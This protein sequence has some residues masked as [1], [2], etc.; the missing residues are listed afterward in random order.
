MPSLTMVTGEWPG[1][2]F[3]ISKDEMVIGQRADCDIFLPD[4]YVSK[5]HALIVR[6]PDGVYVEN[7]KNKNKTRVGGVLLTDPRRLADGDLIE[8]CGYT[9]V[10]AASDDSTGG[11]S[12]I[13]GTIDLSKA[14]SQSLGRGG[15]TEKLR[16]IME[17][18]AELAGHL[19][20][21]AVLEKVLDALFRIFPQAERGFILSR[22][23]VNDSPTAKASKFRHADADH[24]MP[25][26]TVYDLVTREAQAILFE[27]VPADRRFSESGSIVAAE[28]HSVMCAPLWDTQ[29]KPVGI[30]QVD[31]RDRSNR[32]NQDDLEFLVAVAGTISV[33]VENARLHD[34]EIRRRQTEQEAR[35]AW[36]VQ[37]SFIPDRW[38]TLPGYEFWHYYQPARFV[39]GDYFDYLALRGARSTHAKQWV[40]ALGDVAGKGMPAALLMARLSAEVRLLNQVKHDPA[41]VVNLLN[42]SLC[43]KEAAER[44]VTFLMIL[45]DVRRHELTIVNAGHMGPMI[46]RA[47]GS[48]EVI[49]EARSGLPLGIDSE[50]E[51]NTVTTDLNPGDVIVLYTDGVNEA[52]SPSEQDFGMERL[53]QCVANAPKEARL[54]GQAVRDALLTHMADRDQFDDI[55]L[56]CFGRS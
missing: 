21:T 31:T 19:D 35:D 9:L 7:L 46:R 32:F 43:E 29:R 15:V 49:G 12:N 8:I 24:V 51:Y 3:K 30:L 50:Q 26:R 53:R 34:L 2:V 38:P 20:L 55:T 40:I 5:S 41:Q 11:T 28:V 22:G 16:V 52:K 39:G 4:K 44:F 47:S 1:K 42:R 33:A 14:T 13:L 48:I 6:R 27:D 37:R 18:S 54:V 17:I 45:F 56:I 36:A 25:S 10:Y 23:E